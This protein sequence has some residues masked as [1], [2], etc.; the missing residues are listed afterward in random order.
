MSGRYAVYYAPERDSV[1]DVFGKLFLGRCAETGTCFDQPS[2]SDLEQVDILKLTES[3]RFYG[4]H[5]TLVPP[6]HLEST[7]TSGDLM[8]FAGGFAKQC[9]PFNLAPLSVRDIGNFVAMV[10]ARQENIA[11]YAE[12]CLRA[13]HHFR[14]QPS[15]AELERRRA[16]GLTPIQERLL[17]NW[18]YPYVLD[19]FRFHL[20]LT[21]SIRKRGLRK[22]IIKHINDYTESLRKMHHSVRELCIFHQSETTSPFSLIKRFPL[23][24]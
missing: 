2:F 14:E 10:P 3:P 7:Y 12:D 21:D 15:L 9:Q 4:F 11:Q 1:L 13:F 22:K 23:G 17:A 18:G 20:T 5:G 19:E 8:E 6:F 24:K 16:K